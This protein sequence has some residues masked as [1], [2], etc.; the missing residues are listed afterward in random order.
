MSRLRGNP[1]ATRADLEDAVR[2][3]FDGL[4]DEADR[5]LKMPDYDPDQWPDIAREFA[6]DEIDRLEHEL[7]LNDFDPS[8]RTAADQIDI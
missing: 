8:I 6:S 1:D 2:S 3:Y 5:P 4:I 7:K